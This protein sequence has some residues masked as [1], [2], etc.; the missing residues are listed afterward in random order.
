MKLSH[1]LIV[2]AVV[3]VAAAV[4]APFVLGLAPGEAVPVDDGEKEVTIDQVPDAVRETI[5]REAAGNTIEEIEEETEN[6][7]VTY[8]A[9]WHED[10]KEIEIK[11]AADGT[12]LEREVEDDD[13]DEVD[14]D[15]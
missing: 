9:E 8:E 2:G 4:G 13:D 1:W 11:V 3:V 14:D 12:L 5:L 6:G 7:V 10:G 15:D